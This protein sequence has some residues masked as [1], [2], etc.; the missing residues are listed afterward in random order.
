M[1]RVWNGAVYV[2]QQ[3]GYILQKLG[4]IAAAAPPTFSQRLENSKF[5]NYTILERFLCQISG[6]IMNH[7]LRLNLED[8]L[9]IDEANFKTALQLN[10]CIHP[11]HGGDIRSTQEITS[12]NRETVRQELDNYEGKET[13]HTLYYEDF[14]ERRREIEAFVTQ[15]ETIAREAIKLKA[16][17]ENRFK[18]SEVKAQVEANIYENIEADQYEKEQAGAVE[19]YKSFIMTKD[20]VQQKEIKK[21][22]AEQYKQY[23]MSK[24]IVA[25]ELVDAMIKYL[26]TCEKVIEEETGR[27]AVEKIRER[28]DII[29][30]LTH[31]LSVHLDNQPTKPLL[32]AVA[33][34][35]NPDS[36]ESQEAT[37]EKLRESLRKNMAAKPKSEEEQIKEAKEEAHTAY[38]ELFNYLHA[39]TARDMNEDDLYT[40]CKDA[41]AKMKVEFLHRAQKLMWQMPIGMQA[42]LLIHPL[43]NFPCTLN[44]A[45][46]QLFK[47]R[48][49]REGEELP[50][51]PPPSR[52]ASPSPVPSRPATP[53]LR[54][55]L[56]ID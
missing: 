32:T 36:K 20:N 44:P 31:F 56:D 49:P 28:C 22:V 41:W 33:M 7:P 38:Q 53:R 25:N 46:P 43:F 54:H 40:V 27:R 9:F 17:C 16:F 34:G 19:K 45:A 51:T 14:F 12:S 30:D 15:I 4:I 2:R 13:Y 3:T 47:R 55:V 42:P 26:G 5:S 18:A 52:S 10:P 11:L 1:Q 35:A 23:I 39:I 6:C 48:K 37:F 29:R 24:Y 50:P 8:R 21:Y